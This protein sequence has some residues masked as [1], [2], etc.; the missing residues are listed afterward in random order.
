MITD[1]LIV[2]TEELGSVQAY[3]IAA[4]ASDGSVE[5]VPTSSKSIIYGQLFEELKSPM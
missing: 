2:Y 1:Q 4:M 3:G 5:T